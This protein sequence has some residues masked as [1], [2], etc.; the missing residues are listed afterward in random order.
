MSSGGEVSIGRKWGPWILFDQMM[1]TGEFFNAT[2]TGPGYE[3]LKTP[4]I[5]GAYTNIGVE[6]NPEGSNW[7]LALMAEISY[8]SIGNGQ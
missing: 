7:M 3:G 2:I 4:F 8:T 6:G 1:L 5:F